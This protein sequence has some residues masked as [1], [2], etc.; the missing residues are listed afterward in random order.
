M[1]LEGVEEL[2]G[3]ISAIRVGG[4]R[5]K[6]IRVF[7]DNEFAFSLEAEV[8]IKE[9]LQVG[10]ELSAN[11]IKSLADSDRINRCFNAAA[12]YLSYRPR[13]EFEL[14]ERLQKRGFDSGTIERVIARLKGQGLVDDIAFANFWKESRESFSPRS[15]WLTRVE[16]ERKG[17]ATDIIDEVMATSDDSDTAYRAALKKFRS[18]SLSDYESFRYRLGEYLKRRGFNYGVIKHTVERLWQELESGT[19]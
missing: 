7:L 13:S 2:M 6:R 15:Q 5:A 12:R 9:R 18:L 10:Q 19:G 17:I 16:L 8:A 1:L 4:N 14:V 11:H 3:R